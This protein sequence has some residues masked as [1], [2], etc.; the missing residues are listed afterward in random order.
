MKY[1]AIFLTVITTWFITL[2]VLVIQYIDLY[3]TLLK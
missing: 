1:N 3:I 2:T